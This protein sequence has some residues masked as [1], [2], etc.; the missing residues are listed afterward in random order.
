M[1]SSNAYSND[2]TIQ[3]SIFYD[4]LFIKNNINNKCDHPMIR[5][6]LNKYLIAGANTLDSNKFLSG[7]IDNQVFDTGNVCKKFSNYDGNFVAS[8]GN[9][10]VSPI[11]DGMANF[12]V[13]RTKQE[14]SIAFFDKF[15]K[16]L[17]KYP[18]LKTIFPSTYRVLSAIGK[19]IYMFEM[20]I[21]TLREAFNS[22]LTILPSNLH[23]IIDNHKEYFD[24]RP[25]LTSLLRSGF[26]LAQSIQE[27][28]HPGNIIE[29]Y[30]VNIL[31]S[32]QNVKA[33][34]QTLKL[35]SIS[36]KGSSDSAYWIPYSSIYE[37]LIKNLDKDSTLIRIYLGLI[38]QKAKE[39]KIYFVTDTGNCYLENL[40][41]NN[42]TKLKP[43]ITYIRDVIS[44]AEVLDKR[45]SE[46][47]KCENYS[48]KLENFYGVISST[49]DLMRYAAKIEQLSFFKKS[50]SLKFEE[51]LNIYFDIAQS[52]ADIGINIYRKKYS[53]AILNTVQVFTAIDSCVKWNA[54]HNSV[55]ES[56]YKEA[57]SDDDDFYKISKK[58][59]KYG[60]FAA[61]I[62]S[63]KSSSEVEA[64]I[65][66]I[67]LPTGS[68]RIKRESKFNISINAY[69]GLFSGYEKIQGVDYDHSEINFNHWNTW[70]VTVPIGVAFSWSKSLFPLVWLSKYCGF[71]STILLSAIDIGALAAFR[72][73]DMDSTSD[74]PD[75]KIKDIVSPG[76]FYSIGIPKCPISVNIG[77]QIGP[78]L[79]KVTKDA[80]TYSKKY[81]RFGIAACVDIPILN[82]YNKID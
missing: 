80:N 28:Q 3:G 7:I 47:L 51:N 27:K 66:S 13:K 12:I 17:E 49:I 21:Q 64:A 30:D 82:L 39:N 56:L 43:Y 34:F 18:D 6:I 26:Y 48:L 79:R 67:A 14:L 36:F 46:T 70:G 31:D 53:L 52:S 61:L 37:N 54:K 60:S 35:F 38:L 41:N 29:N 55:K 76:V 77:Y 81:S 5:M 22:D 78:L 72:F 23:G 33:A 10:N 65:E 40:M 45:F 9:L 50:D 74:V 44:K 1:L 63:A 20:Y 62:T 57:F 59:T 68:S 4:A 71:S 42:Y 19:D 75:I 73:E 32:V 15:Q 8:L 24:K 11:A 58:L 2:T 25:E 69:C 16:E